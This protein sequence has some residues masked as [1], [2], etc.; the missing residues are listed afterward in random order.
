MEYIM[1]FRCMYTMCKSDKGVERL[2]G[3]STHTHTYTCMHTG[4]HITHTDIYT[5]KTQEIRSKT[6]SIFISN[7]NFLCCRFWTLLCL[8]ILRYFMYFNVLLPYCVR[9]VPKVLPAFQVCFSAL[10]QT[11]FYT[12]TP[13]T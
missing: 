5:Q 9:E 7:N 1:V 4:A 3:R 12:L 2:F 10:Y 11:S 8:V 6:I 13:S